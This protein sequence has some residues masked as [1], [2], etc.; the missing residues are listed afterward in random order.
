MEALR[1]AAAVL[2]HPREEVA[3]ERRVYFLGL[4]VPHDRL[5]VV[6]LH[7]AAGLIEV[8]EPRGRLGGAPE[9]RALKPLGRVPE[10]GR[11]PGSVAEEDAYPVLRRDDA[12]RG[13]PSHQ[14]EGGALVLLHSPALKAVERQEVVSLGEALGGGFPEPLEGLLL[15]RRG[16]IEP[17]A[18]EEPQ[19]ALRCG[20]ALL[21]LGGEDFPRLVLVARLDGAGEEEDAEVEDSRGI[22]FLR[23]LPEAPHRLLPVLLDATLAP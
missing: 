18:V 19:R 5:L 22:I 11:R 20:R 14:G 17:A 21:G 1:D 15:I 6:A 12:A 3:A 23:G 7:A 13:R 9:S 10:I 4:L 16:G 8:A 2:V